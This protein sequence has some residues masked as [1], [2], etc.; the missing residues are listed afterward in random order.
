MKQT[1][2]HII[3]SLALVAV[4][5]SC[6]GLNKM[7][8]NAP[9]VQYTVTPTVLETHGGKVDLEIKAQYPAKFWDKKASAEITPVLVYDGGETVFPSYFVQ[10][11]KVKGNYKVIPYTTGGQETYKNAVLYNDKMRVSNLVIRMKA[12]KGAQT[13]TFDDY[14]IAEGVI[15]TSTLASVD[16]A[17]A[18]KGKDNFQRIVSESQAAEILYLIQQAEVRQGQLSKEDVKAL[19]DYINA[20]KAAENKNFKDVTVSAYA[21]PDGSLELNTGLAGNREK[22]ASK[23]VAGQLKKAKVE[24]KELLKGKTTAED[25]DGFKK[26][27]ENSNIQDK[28]LILRV[29]S[30][31][32]DPEVREKEIKNMAATF[33]VLADEILPSL[34]RSV[35]TVNAELI[36]KSDDELKQLSTS[37]VSSLNLE[38]LLYAA[39]LTEDKNVQENLYKEAASKYPECWRG[40]NNL[41]VVLYNKGDYA[42]AKAQFEKAASIKADPIVENNLGVIALRNNDLAKA[43]EHFGKAAGTGAEL[44]NNLGIIAIFKADYEGAI[45]YFGSSTSC[46]AALAKILAGKYD[47]ALSTLNANT[48][49]VGLKYYLKAIVGAKKSENDLMFENLRKAVSLDSKWKEYAKK[50]MEFGK[51]FNDS[52]FRSIVE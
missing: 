47:A 26:A 15:A 6:A 49:E 36:G 11:E 28:E 37:N 5:S 46:N 14:K 50:D 13:A 41:G 33:K 4:L 25:W 52:T 10:G 7:K 8:K 9:T 34:R 16:G 39:T 17:M 38:E 18:G 20:I 43:E 35:I 42:G 3:G 32:S 19:N 23:Y 12:T 22:S 21:S 51:F 24:D 31:Y 40:V 45:R 44:D 27:V 48:Y 29:L 2:I 1:R 30:M